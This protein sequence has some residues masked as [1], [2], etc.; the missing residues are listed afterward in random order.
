MVQ[1]NEN[2]KDSVMKK[3][4]AIAFTLAVTAAPLLT[5]QAQATPKSEAAMKSRSGTSMESSLDIIR[6]KAG[7]A[8]AGCT[9]SGIA[10]RMCRLGNR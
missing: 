2:R 7:A 1:L 9:G 4:L 3:F 5:T 6:K 10:Y 8:Y